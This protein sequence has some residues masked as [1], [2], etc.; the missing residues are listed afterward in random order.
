[1]YHTFIDYQYVI[2]AC[3]NGNLSIIIIYFFPFFSFFTSNKCISI[4]CN[5]QQYYIN[6]HYWSCE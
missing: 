5:M 6:I 4:K 3:D 2:Y 1:M